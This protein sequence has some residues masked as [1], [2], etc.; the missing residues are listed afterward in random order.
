MHAAAAMGKEG[1]VMACTCHVHAMHI[2]AHKGTL[3]DVL[4]SMHAPA[5]RKAACMMQQNEQH[6]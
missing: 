6:A 4:G 1:M 2:V 3:G 5:L